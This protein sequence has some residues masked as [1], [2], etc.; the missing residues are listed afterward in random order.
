PPLVVI[1]LR[2]VTDIVEARKELEEYRDKLEE[3]VRQRTGELMQS[4]VQLQMEIEERKRAEAATTEA[5]ERFREIIHGMPVM[6]DALSED[7][8]LL[9]WNRECERVTGYSAEEI[10]GNTKAFEMLYPDDEYREKMIRDLIFIEGDFREWEFDIK[11][12]DGS[13]KTIAWSNVSSQVPIPGWFTWAIGVDVTER[14]QAEKALQESEYVMRAQFKGIPVPTYSWQHVDDDFILLDFNDAAFKITDGK[15]ADYVG[16]SANEFYKDQPEILKDMHGCCACGGSV[17][18]VME[19]T[20]RSTGKKAYL[21]VKYACIQPDI[22]IVHTEDITERKETEEELERYRTGLEKLIDERTIELQRVNEQLQQEILERKRTE[23]ELERKNCELGTL[24][25]VYKII[26]AASDVNEILDRILEPIMEFCNAELGG[27]YFL[28]YDHNRLELVSSRGLNDEIVAKVKTVE[29]SVHSVQAILGSSTVFVAE[30]DLNGVSGGRYDAIKEAL[31]VKKTLTFLFK[32]HGRIAY[33]VML[34]RLI[35][36]DVSSGIRRFLE[37]L[38]NQI[39]IAVERL[40]LLSQL[41]R[42]KIELKNLATRLIDSI[43]EEKRNIALSLHDET[44]QTLAA[45]KNELEMLRSRMPAGDKKSK[46]SLEEIRSHILKITEGTRRISYSLHPSQLEDLGLVPAINWY[47][48]KFVRSKYL[49]VEV[50]DAG[51]NEELPLHVG[52]TLYRIAQEALANV[53]RHANAKNVKVNITKGYPDVIM[54]IKDDG[55]GFDTEADPTIEKG[56]GI[57]GMRE[58]V[59]GME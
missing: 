16:M 54:V 31:G 5:T 36:E 17:E 7:S 21:N 46:K 11:C 28:D 18:R 23:M 57:I 43:E 34:G 51:F 9:A 48:E 59:E 13:T 27:L 42:N 38:G 20:F 56:L 3:L 58:R 47:A 1:V 53:V 29:M 33:M 52:L 4:N 50:G 41:E 8:T 32:S 44:G 55:K 39:S 24:N 22:L 10:V 19:Y 2:E 15:I 40:E 14:K 37:M 6:M 45:V 49:K 12:K 26:V 35:D 25:E 30:E